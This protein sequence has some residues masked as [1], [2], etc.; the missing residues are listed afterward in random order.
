MGEMGISFSNEKLDCLIVN[1]IRFM[2][3]TDDIMFD[4]EMFLEMVDSEYQKM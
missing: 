1:Y 2:N 4:I 3:K